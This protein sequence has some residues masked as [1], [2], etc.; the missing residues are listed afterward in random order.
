[1]DLSRLPDYAQAPDFLRKNLV[2]TAGD[3]Q[4]KL[5]NAQRKADVE[6]ADRLKGREQALFNKDTHVLTFA[7]SNL[8]AETANVTVRLPVRFDDWFAAGKWSTMDDRTPAGRQGKTFALQHLMTGVREAY[9]SS[10]NDFINLSIQ[11]KK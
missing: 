2:V 7:V 4:V 11:L 5:T 6:N 10:T 3:A 9:Q 1:M 8:F